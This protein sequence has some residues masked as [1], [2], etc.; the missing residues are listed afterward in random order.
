MLKN[1]FKH[2]EARRRRNQVQTH[3]IEQGKIQHR[4][5]WM[6]QIP[7]NGTGEVRTNFLYYEQHGPKGKVNRFSWVTSI[8]LNR[9]NVLAIMRA[10]RARWKIENETFNTLKNQGYHFEHNYGHGYNHLCNVLAIL[11]LLAFLIDQIIQACS[12]LFQAI[13]SVTK[14]KVRLWE[15]FRALYLTTV[16]HSFNELFDTLAQCYQVQLE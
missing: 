13:W 11:M 8:K 4:F 6:N 14:T 3:I 16:L 7:L 12:R 15:T 5:Y 2:F 1:L 10:G 9:R